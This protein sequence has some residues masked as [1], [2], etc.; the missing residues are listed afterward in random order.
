MKKF[1]KALSIIIAVLMLV[2]ALPVMAVSADTAILKE[3]VTINEYEE[4]SIPLAVEE[5]GYYRIYSTGEFDTYCD[6]LRYDSSYDDY[7]ELAY[8]EDYSEAQLNF[9]MK[10]Y[11]EAGEQY[12]LEVD[13]YSEYEASF[14]VIVEPAD[15][16]VTEVKLTKM[17]DVDFIIEGSEYDSFWVE[18]IELEATLSD[19]TKTEYVYDPAALPDNILGSVLTFDDYSIDEGYFEIYCDDAYAK[20]EMNVVEN[21]VESIE[22][23]GAPLVVEENVDGELYEDVFYYYYGFSDEDT[24]KVCYKDGTSEEININERV[25]TYEP[26][27]Y[28]VYYYDDQFETPWT[29][30]ADNIVTLSYLGFYAE[31]PVEIVPE[32]SLPDNGDDGNDD[33]NDD[34]DYILPIIGEEAEIIEVTVNDEESTTVKF[35]P[36]ASGY[37]QFYSTGEYDTHGL[38]KDAED[39]WYGYANNGLNEED[40][41]FFLK[42][43]LEAG[44][45]YILEISVFENG[46]CVFDVVMEPAEKYVTDIELVKEPDI[47]YVYEGAEFDSFF[48]EGMELE[49]TFSD[50]SK[51]QKKI[52]ALDDIYS[53]ICGSKIDMTFGD[54]DYIRI[55]C[56]EGAEDYYLN[57]IE[58]PV[59]RIEYNGYPF[60]IYEGTNGYYDDM[61]EQFYY[62]EMEFSDSDTVTVYYK[63][64]TSEEI[65]INERLYE[66]EHGIYPLY[67][68]DNQYKEPWTA[69]GEYVMYIEY[70]GC[71]AE[72]PVKIL[73]DSDVPVDGEYMIGDANSDEK[74]NV[75]D[76]TAIQKAIASLITLDA[77]QE[78]AA[79]ADGNGKVNIKDATAIQ[80]FAAGMDTGLSIG[81]MA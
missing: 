68:Y 8:F 61:D 42:S 73:A 80:K 45:T 77:T 78:A 19:G 81:E 49:F 27:M 29:A 60:E 5:S 21:P 33:G 16:F 37:Y 65:N 17:P 24:F 22:Y 10:W 11:L 18:G 30:G 26:G 28:P 32:G 1:K 51:E 2:S 34:P 75:K 59:D 43:Y 31:V 9:D 53:R 50:G 64:G 54:D 15:F 46:E 70:L 7:E 44:E 48:P 52:E 71:E 79:D 47:N 36:D 14:Q 67:T 66:Y 76:A 62:T 41:N 3:T 23:T 63:D 20:V 55:T 40:E 39:W 12:E 74:I 4:V 56:D 58:N 6:L 72:V 69:G 38:L 13:V 35:T 57:I 25:Y